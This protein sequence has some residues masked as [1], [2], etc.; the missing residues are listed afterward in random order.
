MKN[1]I[2][3]AKINS[4]IINLEDRIIEAV[5]STDRVDRDDDVIVQEGIDFTNYLNNPVVLLNHDLEGTPIAKT[6]NLRQ[7]DGET[8][9]RMQFADSQVSPSSA[10]YFD[11]YANGYMNGFSA[12]LLNKRIEYRD[13]VRVIVESELIEISLV[14][15]PANPETVHKSFE[16]ITKSYNTQVSNYL[17][18]GSDLNYNSGMSKDLTAD[19]NELQTLEKKYKELE[20]RLESSTNEYIVKIHDLEKSNTELTN[21]NKS[22]EDDNKTL[23][24][25]M[26]TKMSDNVDDTKDSKV[27]DD[28]DIDD[29]DDDSDDDQELT[30]EQSTKYFDKIY[31]KAIKGE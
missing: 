12:G 4:K 2:F 26:N 3:F 29:D 21:K 27:D 1:P 25:I 17:T 20:A 19:S 22:L 16:M 13:D 6:I 5:I 23:L 31:N 11:L 7:V 28:K 15:I 8:I 18:K 10:F 14:V 24:K 30:P 9:A